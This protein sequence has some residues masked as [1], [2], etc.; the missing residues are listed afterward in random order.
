MTSSTSRPKSRL[1][2]RHTETTHTGRNAILSDCLNS[3]LKILTES[4][5]PNMDSF[6]LHRLEFKAMIQ[7]F[8]VSSEGE[9]N[10]V[11]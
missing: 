8:S 1:H 10:P 11:Q 5:E 2:R 4:E 9:K 6:P 3:S 7:V